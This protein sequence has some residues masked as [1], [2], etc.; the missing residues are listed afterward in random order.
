MSTNQM[1]PAPEEKPRADET[2]RATRPRDPLGTM[3]GGLFLIVLGI[4][5]FLAVNNLYGVTWPNVWGV[6]LIGFGI[7]L[8]LEALLRAVLPQYRRGVSG[9]I[10]GGFVLIA[11]GL[12]PFAGYN[13]AAYWPVILIVIGLAILI[14]QFARR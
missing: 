7:I 11:V 2:R 8:L 14:G 3:T 9:R 12:I 10:I 13:W 4:A 5:F 6:F 1:Q